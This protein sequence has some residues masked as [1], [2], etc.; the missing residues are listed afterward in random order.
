MSYQPDEFTTFAALAQMKP[1]RGDLDPR[2][3]KYGGLWVYPV[4]GLLKIASSAGW[5]RVTPDPAFYLDHPE[6]FGRF[7]VVARVYSALWGMMGAVAIFLL[8]RRI[9]ANTVA[10][11]IAGLCFVSMPVVVTAAHEAKPHLAG[12][13][14]TLMAV[15]A[16]GSFVVSGRKTWGLLTALLCGAA[17]GMVPSAIPAMLI[18]P[19]MMLMRSGSRVRLVR[20]LA[21][22]LL[23]VGLI[24]CVTNPY[25]AINLVRDRA[26]LR[27]NFSNSSDFYHASLG[28]LPNAA[29]LVGLGTGAALGVVGMAGAIALGVR[30]ARTGGTTPQEQARRAAGLLLV[31]ATIPTGIVFAVY[32]ARQPADYGRFALPFNLFLLVEAIV[33]IASFVR[34]KAVRC[35][36]F[37]LLLFATAY[38]GVA[39]LRGFIRDSRE[40]TTRMIA[41]EKI[42]QSESDGAVLATREE[43]APWSLPPVDLFRWKVVATPR[44]LPADQPFPGARITIGPTTTASFSDLLHPGRSTPLSWASKPFHI[45]MNSRVP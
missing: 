30:A 31:A 14:L 29:L 21:G 10:A 42:R 4:G 44:D 6:S 18:L 39:Y 7:Y 20:D 19:V 36:C 27:S 2:M 25:V 5:V 43:P 26:V 8:V 28:G 9:S 15:L 16:G 12:A 38:P 41:A 13:A 33:A 11:L 1:G 37:A 3:Y 35:V 17:I 24:Y 45:E 32:A 40:Q 22:Y 23:I 34:P